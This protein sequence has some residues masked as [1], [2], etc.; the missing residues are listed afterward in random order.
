MNISTRMGMEIQEIPEVVERLLSQSGS[1]AE[2]VA[3]ALREKNPDFLVTVARGSSDHAAAFFKYACELMLGLPVASLGPSTASI[4]GKSLRLNNAACISVSQSGQSPDIV[5]AADEATRSGA[6]SIAITNE[7][8][9]P[10]ASHCQHKLALCAGCERSVPATKTFIA[11]LFMS[12]L[13]LA[14]W[15]GDEGL[16]RR[17]K[18]LPAL[19]ADAVILN[20]PEL[21]AVI[22]RSPSLFVL[23][24]GPCWSISNEAALK[25]KETC[26]IHAES[27]SAAEVL[28]GPVQIVEAG[29]PV[30]AL[31][32]QD[33]AEIPMLETCMLLQERGARLFGTSDSFDPAMRLDAVRT[34]HPLIDPITVI[35]SFY[36]CAEKLSLETGNDPDHPKNLTKITETT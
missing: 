1:N 33:A 5:T 22:R 12:L 20:W 24:R 14:Y 18:E 4:Y 28:H 11:S 17:L 10:L 34:G 3:M 25:L 8:D 32:A 36:S 23:G 16:V 35:A 29:F 7:I 2:Q 9:S 21:R 13:L 19:L 31:I 15:K 6:L 27:Y 30:I 26:R